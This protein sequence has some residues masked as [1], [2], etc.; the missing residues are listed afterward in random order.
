MM[1]NEAWS[2]MQSWGFCLTFVII[3]NVGPWRK[4]Y[5]W[6]YTH[7]PI[8]IETCESELLMYVIDCLLEPNI[9]HPPS[10]DWRA[11]EAKKTRGIGLTKAFVRWR[12]ITSFQICHTRRLRGGIFSLHWNGW[13]SSPPWFRNSFLLNTWGKYD[14]KTANPF[15]V[16][17][18]P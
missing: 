9:S 18:A 7:M 11:S 8:W 12:L 4:S 16:K 10:L 13:E 2:V 14:L 15:D 1:F 3:L 6:N 5:F 17:V